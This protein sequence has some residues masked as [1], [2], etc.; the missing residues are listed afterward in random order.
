[1]N[2]KNPKKIDEKGESGPK[3]Y[4]PFQILCVIIQKGTNGGTIIW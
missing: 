4:G 2:E 1:M 3:H